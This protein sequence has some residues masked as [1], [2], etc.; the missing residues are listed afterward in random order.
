MDGISE[1]DL[2]QSLLQELM[3]RRGN[4][5]YVLADSSKPPPAA[6]PRVWF[7][8]RLPW[9]LIM[10]DGADPT[11]VQK[12]RDVVEIEVAAVRDKS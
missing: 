2:A 11:Q 9:T 3:A 1:A 10:D 5:I 8:P 7:G 4:S 12:F 6:L